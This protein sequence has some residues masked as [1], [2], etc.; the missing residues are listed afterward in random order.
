MCYSALHCC[1][2]HL[3]QTR[4]ELN[5]GAG[6]RW[7]RS[8]QSQWGTKFAL[9]STQQLG[10]RQN[11]ASTLGSHP[12]MDTLRSRKPNSR[13]SKRMD[14]LPRFVSPRHLG[15]NL[16]KQR[17]RRET[18]LTLSRQHDTSA[19]LDLYS[20]RNSTEE[21]H[22]GSH[23]PSRRRT[24]FVYSPHGSGNQSLRKDKNQG[25]RSQWHWWSGLKST[26]MWYI[27]QIWLSQ[28]RPLYFFHS[29][30]FFTDVQPRCNRN[31]LARKDVC[32]YLHAWYRFFAL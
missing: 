28:C 27:I 4:H 29:S 19:W 25:L 2:E 11:Q 5:P 14:I 17:P 21:I 30:L 16:E 10:A 13:V 24:P 32:F 18:S 31:S 8:N 3:L 22:S 9:R 12:E 6:T 20:E 23:A 26:P 1:V 7:A 15:F